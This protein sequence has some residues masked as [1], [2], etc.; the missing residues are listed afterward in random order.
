M[1]DFSRFSPQNL[2]LRL[3]INFGE[4]ALFKD[5]GEGVLQAPP[6]RLR[7]RAQVPPRRGHLWHRSFGP[8]ST[9][10]Q[11][12]C[13]NHVG[14]SLRQSIQDSCLFGIEIWGE[15]QSKVLFLVIFVNKF[16]SSPSQPDL[17]WPKLL[18]WHSTLLHLLLE[19][20]YSADSCRYTIVAAPHKALL[21]PRK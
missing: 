12:L 21:V 16:N 5:Q 17:S 11:V 4:C 14:R 6:R 13:I 15:F 2:W 9:S 3:E 8:R 10:A 1:L 18:N 7:D 19:R 20:T